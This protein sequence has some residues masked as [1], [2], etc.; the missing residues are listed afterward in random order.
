MDNMKFGKFI[1]ELRKEKNMTQKELAQKLNLTDK[2]ISKWER[3]IG[4]PDIAMLKPLAEIF[5][6]SIIELLNGEKENVKEIDLDL[7]ILTILKEKESEKKKKVGKVIGISS[8]I[9]V[10]LTITLYILIFSK[11]ELKTCNPIRAAIGYAE[12]VFLGKEY[13]E[14]G[15]IPTK[16][17]YANGNFDIEKYM[18]KRGYENVGGIKTGDNFYV[19]GE[20]R[21]L[22]ERW[23]VAGVVAYEWHKE[24]DCSAEKI[25]ELRKEYKQVKEREKMHVLNDNNQK[26]NEIQGTDVSKPSIEVPLNIVMPT[27]SI[28]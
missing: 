14:V 25:E 3:G 1:Q 5:N 19:K 21:V 9:I 20:T 22:V 2:A 11:G 6:V 24:V 16:T 8:T 27:N 17:I 23:S 26:I 4:F 28:E 12:V 7:R 15:N 13:V 18:E 10:I